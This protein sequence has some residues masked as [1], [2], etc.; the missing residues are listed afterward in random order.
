MNI[1][2]G[3]SSIEELKST[4]QKFSFWMMLGVVI[5]SIF[6]DLGFV[7]LLMRPLNKIIGNKLKPVPSPSSFDFTEVPSSTFEFNRLDQRINEMMHKLRDAFQIEKEFISNVSHEL[8]TPI[9]IIQNRLENIIIEG[10]L[11]EDVMIR[12]TDSQRTLSRMSR[13]IKALLLISQIENDQYIKT[14]SI[15]ISSLINEVAEEI[16]DRTNQREIKLMVNVDADL[17]YSPCNRALLFTMFFNLINNAIKYNKEKGSIA[18]TLSNHNDKFQ[19]EIKDTG[20]GIEQNQLGTIFD[21]FIRLNKNSAEGF[22]LGLPIV[23]TIA[24]FHQIEVL[25]ASEAGVGTTFTLV[26]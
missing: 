13:I 8:Q 19:V 3:I 15:K 9:S 26:F 10:N 25:V 12:L 7:S 14:E 24:S 16:E 20:I 23:K 11:S 17:E 5:I 2:E 6:L 22:G 1:G 21:R 4:I 18:I